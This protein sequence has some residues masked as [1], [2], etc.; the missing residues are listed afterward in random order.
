MGLLKRNAS[1]RLDFDTFFNHPFIRRPAHSVSSE[2]ARTSPTKVSSLD[3]TSK[4]T[5]PTTNAKGTIPPETEREES[6]PR[7]Y[8]LPLTSADIIS[9]T[10]TESPQSTQT[11]PTAIATVVTGRK[12]SPKTSNPLYTT[13]RGHQMGVTQSPA[14]NKH[15]TSTGK[16]I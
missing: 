4:Q 13:P 11:P 16:L 8:K 7:N 1:D 15:P 12:T 14:S 2:R 3:K 10:H 9:P 5:T 6:T